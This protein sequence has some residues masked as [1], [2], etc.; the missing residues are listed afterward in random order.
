MKTIYVY[1]SK[2]I[3]Y[4]DVRTKEYLLGVRTEEYLLATIRCTAAQRGWRRPSAQLFECS[5]CS[6]TTC[7]GCS[8][9]MFCVFE[10]M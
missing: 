10:N 9:K 5:G 7:R 2:F 8:N 1:A 6:W 3:L 4:S